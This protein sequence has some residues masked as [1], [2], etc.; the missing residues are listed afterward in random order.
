MS[1]SGLPPDFSHCLHIIMREEHAPVDP[2]LNETKIT[3][4]RLD[5]L[6]FSNAFSRSGFVIEPSTITTSGSAF[7]SQL[8][9]RV[10]HA[11]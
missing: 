7:T 9:K 11:S 4:V 1:D 6:I 8:A 2:A 3:F 10:T 5:V